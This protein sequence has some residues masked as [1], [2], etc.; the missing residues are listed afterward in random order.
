MSPQICEFVI[1]VYLNFTGSARGVRNPSMQDDEAKEQI[2]REDPAKM[3]AI[4]SLCSSQSALSFWIMQS[5]SIH[6]Y[7]IPS[8]LHTVI[9]SLWTGDSSSELM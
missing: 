7:R 4:C 2:V 1:D 9:A 3:L 8:V 6:R 5:E